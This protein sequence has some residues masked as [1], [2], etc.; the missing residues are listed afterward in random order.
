MAHKAK[1]NGKDKFESYYSEIYK[2]RWPVLKEAMLTQSTTVSLS[3]KLLTP[4]F[5]DK[6]SIIAA[7]QLPVKEND[8]VLDMCAA[9]GGKTLVLALKLNGTGSLKSNDRSSD[10]R[11][12]LHKVI[13]SSLPQE[14]RNN[15]TITGHDS[16][17]WSLYEKDVYDCILLDA[18][19][20]S[21][22]HVINDVKALSIWGLN[23]PKSLAITQFSMLAAALDAVKTGGYILYSTCSINPMENQDIITKLHKKREGRFEEI[24]LYAENGI[25]EKLEHGRIILP[26]TSDNLGP[27]FFCLIRRLS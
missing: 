1:E 23:R 6:A 9:P 19:C 22:R 10:R 15:I 3:D 11:S 4:Y 21:E 26:D 12:R 13:E 20:S 8:S 27:L 16:T 17:K 7:G 5:M 14:L 2:D 24:E 18:P 25:S